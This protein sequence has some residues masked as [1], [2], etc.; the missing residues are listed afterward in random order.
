MPGAIRRFFN[1]SK[2]EFK[3]RLLQAVLACLLSLGISATPALAHRRAMGNA[4]APT[5][6]AI[7][8][9]SH[10]QMDVVADNMDD[11]LELADRQVPGDPVTRR[12]QGFVSQQY[13]LCLRGMVPGSL[14]DE[15]SPFNECSHAYLAGVH[16]LLMHLRATYGGHPD[17]RDLVARIGLEMARNNTSLVMCRYSDEPFNTAEL[18]SPHWSEIASHP[19]S[20]ATF[21]GFALVLAGCACLPWRRRSANSSRGNAGRPT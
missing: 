18:I 4:A 17:V 13:F 10:G 9:L 6:I 21:G 15:T 1:E 19:P 8:N 3:G 20:P 2:P 16:A 7:P 11:I 14:R 5:G 12:L